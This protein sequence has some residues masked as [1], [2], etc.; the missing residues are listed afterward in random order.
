[1]SVLPALSRI[2]ATAPR[3]VILA[4]AFAFLLVSGPL[5]CR[6]RPAKD[7]M[8][9]PPRPIVEV[10]ADHTPE[11]MAIPGVVGTAESRT[12]DGR[13]CILVLLANDSA[14]L[15]AKLPRE[16]EG[17]PVILEV[18]GEIRAMPDSSR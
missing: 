5:G 18:T 7:A 4:G 11:L 2:T 12:P 17:W 6:E 3:P 9:P 15:R 10:L 16:L 13:P 14:E 1:V 8:A